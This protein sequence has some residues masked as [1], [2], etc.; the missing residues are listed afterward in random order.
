M[1]FVEAAF[2]A[3]ERG[4]ANEVEALAEFLNGRYAEGDFNKVAL[5]TVRALGATCVTGC[6]IAQTGKVSKAPSFEGFTPH[7]AA[8]AAGSG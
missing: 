5:A 4:T 3:M 6:E 8:C 2:R 7:L 1:D